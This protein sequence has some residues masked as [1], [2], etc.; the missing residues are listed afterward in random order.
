MEKRNQ[1]KQNKSKIGFWIPK[2]LERKYIWN[3]RAS[4][5]QEILLW[6]QNALSFMLQSWVTGVTIGSKAMGGV[7]RALVP[8]Y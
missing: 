4:L 7:P 5:R 2:N 8:E 1:T 6:L 3:S